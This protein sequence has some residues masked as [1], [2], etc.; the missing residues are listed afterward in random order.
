MKRYTLTIE[1]DDGTWGK[2]NFEAA[3]PSIALLAA[4]KNY[5]LTAAKAIHIVALDTEEDA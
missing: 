2:L 3:N 4:A 1:S 5:D